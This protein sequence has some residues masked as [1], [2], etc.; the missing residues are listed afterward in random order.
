MRATAAK[1]TTYTRVG[2]RVAGIDG[3]GTP[4]LLL[5]DFRARGLPYCDSEA[6]WQPLVATAT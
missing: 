5:K 2:V 4:W 6:G 1:S 3:R